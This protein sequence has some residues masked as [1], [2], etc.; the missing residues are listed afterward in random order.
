MAQDKGGVEHLKD[1]L[2]SRKHQGPIQDMRSTLSRGGADVPVAWEAPPPPPRAPEGPRQFEGGMDT[3]KQKKGMAFST[4]F[5]IASMLFFVA[6]AGAAA[7]YFVGGGNFVSP[8]NI[9][10]QIVAPSL[11]DG[12]S[13]VDFQ[14]LA[15]N[16]NSSPLILSDLVITYPA[17]TRDPKDPQKPLQTERQS[18]GTIAPGQAIKRT[19]S[20]I[21]YGQEGGVQ[22]VHVALEY[23]LEGSNAVFVRE[24]G[25]ELTLGSSPV[26]VTVAAPETAA[27]GQSFTMDVTVRSNSQETVD[28]VALEA[29]YPFGFTVQSASPA[30]DSGQKL[31]HLGSL[32]PGASTVVRITGAIDG[33]D[34]DQRIFRFLTGSEPDR[35]AAHIKIPFINTPTAITVSRPFVSAQLAVAGKTGSSVSVSPGQNIQGTVSW[36]NN[37]SDSVSNIEVSLKLDGPALDTQSVQSPNGFYQSS[38]STITWTSAQD[39]SL[40]QVAPGA[41]G[42]LSFSFATLPPGTGGIVYTNPKV[43]LTLNVK[44]TRGSD[45]SPESVSALTTTDVVVGSL[46]SLEAQSRFGGGPYQNSGPTPP[47]AEQPTTYT[48]A[49]T[50]KNS[51]NAIANAQVSAVLPPYVSYK[52]GQAGVAYDAPSRTVRWSLGELK[53]GTGYTTAAQTAAFQVTLNP[54]VSQVGQ[55]PALTGTAELSGTDRFAQIQVSAQAQAPTTQTADGQ[56]GVVQ[57]K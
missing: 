3:S 26:S 23:S 47:R 1:K 19:S 8:N 48:V 35:T 45:Q 22:K 20:A 37:L 53:A 52:T 9:D 36:K 54:S 56:N 55:A 29:Q 13:Q 21:L 32:K 17:G 10:L 51:S 39:P 49:W 4:K 44:G 50:A 25:V 46:L 18:V 14:I 2:Y 33:Q 11:A 43:T 5:F 27:S 15:T 42:N 41:T 16:R 28:D 34:G 40:A 31:W 6:A 12:G 38:D 57:G 24:S 30:A 7:Y